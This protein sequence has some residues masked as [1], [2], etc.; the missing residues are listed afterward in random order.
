MATAVVR[1]TQGPYE[2]YRVA[3][4]G[5]PFVSQPIRLATDATLRINWNQSGQGKFILSLANRDP[6]LQSTPY[7]RV[8]FELSVGPSNGSGE[9]SFVAGEYV[10][11][12]EEADGAWEVWVE[13]AE[14]D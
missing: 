11:Q 3:G 4:E 2:L 9:Y 12:V 14:V 8:I 10:L 1:P 5:S 13:W 7:G 6:A